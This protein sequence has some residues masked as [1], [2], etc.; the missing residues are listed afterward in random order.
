MAK[1]K[2]LRTCTDEEL[3]ERDHAVYSVSETINQH[4]ILKRP[5]PLRLHRY[6]IDELRKLHK[7]PLPSPSA[8][9]N[10]LMIINGVKIVEDNTEVPIS[11]KGQKRIKYLPSAYP[12][13]E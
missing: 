5:Q 10:I 2:Q 4:A 13:K 7:T 9:Y 8:S 12:I 3:E 6:D 1:N 11:I